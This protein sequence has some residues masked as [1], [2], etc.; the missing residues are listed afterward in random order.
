MTGAQSSLS[1]VR[2]TYIYNTVQLNIKAPKM[3][4]LC[5]A[6]NLKAVASI[7]SN[8][9][10]C[11]HKKFANYVSNTTSLLPEIPQYHDSPSI[12]QRTTY[13]NTKF[14]CQI[15]TLNSN[16]K[17]L[18]SCY[19]HYQLR[20]PKVGNFT[21]HQLITSLLTPGS[22]LLLGKLTGLQLVKKFPTFYGTRRFINAFTRAATCPYPEPAQSRIWRDGG[23]L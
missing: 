7:F 2:T 6:A 1:I 19:L 10:K 4:G 13:F 12:L 17:F 18:I 21:K 3:S 16:T 11:F 22:R 5:D 23:Q 9:R 8:W 14:Q 20:P 15:P